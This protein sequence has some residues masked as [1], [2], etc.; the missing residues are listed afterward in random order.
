M[1]DQTAFGDGRGRGKARFDDIYDQPDP[2]AYFARLAPLDYQIP[3]HAQAEFRRTLAERLRAANRSDRVAVLDLCCSYGINAALLNHDLT[4]ADLY[5]HYTGPA[6]DRLTTEELVERDKQ[7]YAARRHRDAVPVVG[8]DIAGN[9]LSYALAVG[10]LDDACSV[11]LEREEP[12]ASV[13]R[14]MAHTGLILSTG[15]GSYVTDRTVSALLG[16]ARHPVWISAFI[17]R[18][19]DY[20]PVIDCLSSYGLVTR[21]DPAD[22]H[23][24]RLFVTPDEQRQAVAAVLRSGQAPHGLESAGRYYAR[25]YRSRPAGAWA[26]RPA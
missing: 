1:D 12:D 5:A 6:S 2:R 8:L 22:L 17:L 10:L 19:V 20:Q 16:Q 11:N 26:D 13:R 23:P 14:A 9:A 3:H 18:T 4:L 7:F 15:A 24:Q 21:S 25:L